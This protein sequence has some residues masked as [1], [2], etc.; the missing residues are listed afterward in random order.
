VSESN[1]A[2]LMYTCI[3]DEAIKAKM[4]PNILFTPRFSSDIMSLV[5]ATSVLARVYTTAGSGHGE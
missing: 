1:L 3:D 4:T 5:V 2:I